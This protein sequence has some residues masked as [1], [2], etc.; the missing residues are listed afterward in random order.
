MLSHE[1]QEPGHVS[2][3]VLVALKVKKMDSLSAKKTYSSSS[4]K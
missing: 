2:Q 1:V 3:K 4:N